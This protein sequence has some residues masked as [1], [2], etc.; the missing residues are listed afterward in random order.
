MDRF[1]ILRHDD[2]RGLHWDL[3][4]EQAGS[5]RTWSLQQPP[6]LGEPIDGRALAD[7]RK[8]YLDYEGPVSG[9]RGTVSRHDAG[10]Y[11]TLEQAD[12]R[13]VV[14][15]A[16]EVLSAIATLS[17]LPDAAGRW[18]LRLEPVAD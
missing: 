5:L 13:L 12:D 4:L 7:H 11:R 3:M 18:Q 6:Q 10:T 2:P 8:D 16:G 14:Q 17:R 9:G 1:V 15:L